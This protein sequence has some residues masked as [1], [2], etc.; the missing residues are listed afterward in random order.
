M[1]SLNLE[2]GGHRL[3]VSCS[4]RVAHI[5]RAE[6]SEHLVSDTAPLGF[7]VRPTSLR[8]RHHVL[9]DRCGFVLGTTRHVDEVAAMVC[10][11]ASALL[12]LAEGRA[13]FRI[14]AL[15][16]QESV[17]LCAFPM[18]FIP[19]FDE[20]HVAGTGH[21]LVDRLAVDIDVSS[22]EVIFDRRNWMASQE[23]APGHCRPN[24]RRFAVDQIIIPTAPGDHI[25]AAAAVASLCANA[26]DCAPV[27]ALSA[28]ARLVENARSLNARHFG[29]DQTS[30]R[31]ALARR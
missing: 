7:L 10:D 6:L 23:A 16:T 27:I 20:N 12:P 3:Q 29:F 5:L 2:I 26:L 18:L 31:D 15:A 19:A 28:A 11:H 1:T 17:S 4:R 14:R 21:D 13:R 24:G 9:V 8:Q 22:G 25:G 30:L